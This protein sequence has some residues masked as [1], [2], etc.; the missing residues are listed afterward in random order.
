MDAKSQ[1]CA[2]IYIGL[3]VKRYR[4]CP[5]SIR[6]SYNPVKHRSTAVTSE[7][8]NSVLAELTFDSSE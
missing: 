6:L 5:A 8:E 2:Y 3:H 1:E 7:Y 4:L